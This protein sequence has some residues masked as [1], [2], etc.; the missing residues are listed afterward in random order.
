MLHGAVAGGEP[1]ADFI[2][3][4]MERSHAASIGDA[5]GFV[6]DVEALGPGRV[7]VVRGVVDVVDAEGN[8]VVETLDEIVGDGYALSQSFRLRIANVVLHVGLHLPLVGGMSFAHV[9]SQE[10]GVIFVVVVNL[11]HVTDVAAERRSSV[12]AEDDDEGASARA[13]A[14]VEVISAI[15]SEEPSV[16]SIIADLERATV[17]VRQSIAEHAVDILWAACHFA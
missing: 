14:N 5:A 9:N 8:R 12:A 13:F 10:I 3:I 4:V 17:H 16:R 7:S 6:D 15:E 2:G 1:A 11:H